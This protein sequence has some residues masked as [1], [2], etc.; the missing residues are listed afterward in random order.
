MTTPSTPYL[1]SGARHLVTTELK[2]VDVL[3]GR[4]TGPNTW[5]GNLMFRDL[6]HSQVELYNAIAKNDGEQHSIALVKSIIFKVH[7]KGGRFVRKL[8]STKKKRRGG[9]G[10][11]SSHPNSMASNDLL[12]LAG[13]AP[14]VCGGCL[15]NN[16]SIYEIVTD[17]KILICK[18]KQALRYSKKSERK[19]NDVVSSC[20]ARQRVVN[21]ADSL[22]VLPLLRSLKNSPDE[23]FIAPSSSTNPFCSMKDTLES[24]ASLQKDNAVATFAMDADTAKATTSRP[25]SPVGNGVLDMNRSLSASKSVPENMSVS[26]EATSV[27]PIITGCNATHFK[28]TD[29]I[30]GLVSANLS[31]RSFSNV[32]QLTMAPFLFGRQ[33]L[34]Q[35]KDT[36][37]SLVSYQQA[38]SVPH[39]VLHTS[40]NSSTTMSRLANSTSKHALL[41]KCLS[42]YL[43]RAKLR[44]A[45]EAKSLLTRQSNAVNSIREGVLLLDGLRRGKTRAA[46]SSVS[47][48]WSTPGMSFTEGDL[49]GS[50]LSLR[51]NNTA[52]H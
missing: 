37:K 31:S 6:V 44:Q 11:R 50:S 20:S 2:D 14:A 1:P 19:S 26:L 32:D 34:Q 27:L 47:S 42:Q 40:G 48:C 3:L 23:E 21:A 38:F 10:G 8:A 4:G 51:L 18:T 28:L 29:P 5:V 36:S 15:N 17:M 33:T 46:T 25:R 41:D 13:V 52:N 35:E 39:P 30:L 7:A 49:A 16:A 24:S 45:V 43:F 12:S 22:A 9:G